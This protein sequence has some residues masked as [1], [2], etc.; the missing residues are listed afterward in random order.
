M[1][2][3]IECNIGAGPA[4]SHFVYLRVQGKGFASHTGGDFLFSYNFALDAITPDV[5]S[6]RGGTML[7]LSGAG[8]G[9]NV[10]V[11]IG[12]LACDLVT[13]NY[14]SINCITPAQVSRFLF[15]N[16]TYWIYRLPHLY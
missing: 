15:Y 8:F 5:G 14:S 4:G 12:G 10:T 11:T 7:Y 13:F 9:S 16:V 1:V 6:V 3:L 2:N